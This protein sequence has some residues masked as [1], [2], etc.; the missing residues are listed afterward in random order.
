MLRRAFFRRSVLF[1]V[2]VVS[3]LGIILVSISKECQ[4]ADLEENGSGRMRT[5]TVHSAHSDAVS[6]SDRVRDGR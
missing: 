1:Q 4:N 5:V 3:S 2:P 6:D